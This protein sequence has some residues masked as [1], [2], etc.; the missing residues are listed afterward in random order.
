MFRKVKEVAGLHRKRTTM[1]LTNDRNQLMLEEQE[2]KNT[3]TSYIESNFEDDRADAVNVHEGTGPTILKSEVIHAFSIAKKRKAYGPDDIP[4]E[5]P[6]LIVEENIDL[7]VKLFN[8]I[9]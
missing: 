8:S 4:T 3:W 5:A 1:S 9:L 6:K 7:V 2:L